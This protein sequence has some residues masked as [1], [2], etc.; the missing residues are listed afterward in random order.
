MMHGEGVYKWKDGRKYV[1]SYQND[2][3]NGF[4]KYYWNDGRIFE[5]EWR[6]GKR[7]G[8]GRILYPNGSVKTGIWENDKRVEEENKSERK[9]EKRKMSPF[10]L[11]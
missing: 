7:N 8:K 9:E 10:K 4:G 5:G 11:V 1:G 6:N 2:K 3:K